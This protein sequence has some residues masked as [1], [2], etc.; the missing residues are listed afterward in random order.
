MFVIGPILGLG[1][2]TK[3]SLQA[4][5][6]FCDL[7]LDIPLVAVNQGW[8]DCCGCKSRIL[9]QGDQ[10]VKPNLPGGP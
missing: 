5:C 9:I 8:V 6:P 2:G 4:P 3:K 7:L 10:L 1:M